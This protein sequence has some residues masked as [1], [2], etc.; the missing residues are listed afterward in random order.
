MNETRSN[1]ESAF[2]VVYNGQLPANQCG[3]TKREYAAIQFMAAIIG[4]DSNGVPATYA[5]TIASDARV[6]ADALFRELAK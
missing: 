4:G 1:I 6:F 2:P 5:Q 3:L